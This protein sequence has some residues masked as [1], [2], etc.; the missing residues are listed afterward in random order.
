MTKEPSKP[1]QFILYGDDS[2]L[3][4]IKQELQEVEAKEDGVLRTLEVLEREDVE[5]RTQHSEA[6]QVQNALRQEKALYDSRATDQLISRKEKEIRDAAVIIQ[7]LKGQLPEL[8]RKYAE[9]N[10][11]RLEEASKLKSFTDKV[12]ALIFPEARHVC[13]AT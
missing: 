8:K 6:Q 10:K 3:E 1:S 4:I 2:K 5:L 13:L 9:K 12:C 11:K 7:N